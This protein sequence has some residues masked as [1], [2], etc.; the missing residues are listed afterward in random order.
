[1]GGDVVAAGAAVAA[2]IAP[3]P[4]YDSKPGKTSAPKKPAASD[5]GSS[6]DQS[7]TEAV[8][9][10]EAKGRA[11]AA[12]E[13][14]QAEVKPIGRVKLAGLFVFLSLVIAAV[15]VFAFSEDDPVPGGEPEPEPEVKLLPGP[16]PE[17]TDARVSGCADDPCGTEGVQ[18]CSS[19][20]EWRCWLNPLTSPCVPTWYATLAAA[21]T[22]LSKLLEFVGVAMTAHAAYK[23]F[24][25]N[26]GH[27]KLSEDS[28]GGGRRTKIDPEMNEWTELSE[29][30]PNR[31]HDPGLTDEFDDPSAKR[32]RDAYAG[33]TMGL[34]IRYGSGPNEPGKNHSWGMARKVNHMG[35]KWA[36]VKSILVFLFWH[37]LQPTLYFLVFFDAY[38]TLDPM[39]QLL[40]KGVAIREGMY[41][42]SAL[43]CTAVNP[44][45]LLI[46]IHASYKD[47]T[48]FGSRSDALT[49]AYSGWMFLMM[50]VL[51]PE[52]FVAIVMFHLCDTSR[53]GEGE[54]EGCATTIVSNV[55]RCYM[56][57][58]VL[59]DLCGVG[60]LG[61]GL[62]ARNLPSA[63]AVGY[64]AAAFS[65]PTYLVFRSASSVAEGSPR[66]ESLSPKPKESYLDKL[67]KEALDWF[68][69]GPGGLIVCMG[70]FVVPYILAGDL[71]GW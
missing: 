14:E 28:G 57:V 31:S 39:Q 48:F 23:R 15:A 46:N 10:A 2:Q 47:T 22:I 13:S 30:T 61:A 33:W 32:Y 16:V 36:L 25:K 8:A 5:P 26:V 7:E 9:N 45:F 3:P 6:D 70:A 38:S 59:L 4:I 63:L 19:S 66:K 62:G 64:T 40:G 12:A 60:A 17:P 18:S 69:D 51:S 44:S 58:G 49:C 68:L 54:G 11:R 43:I 29:L 65:S 42:A 56:Y 35:Y 34:V 41:L 52:R 71:L 50:Y 55:K 67:A 21:A 1:M 20:C 24:C 27:Q 53:E 37:M